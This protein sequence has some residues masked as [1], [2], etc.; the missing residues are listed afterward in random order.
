M[1]VEQYTVPQAY[2]N[3]LPKIW[4]G[5]MNKVYSSAWSVCTVDLYAVQRDYTLYYADTY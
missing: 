5:S 1:P 2:V 4:P 3:L